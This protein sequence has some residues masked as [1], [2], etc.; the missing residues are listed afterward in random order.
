MLNVD[1]ENELI[2]FKARL[3]FKQEELLRMVHEINILHVS[4]VVTALATADLLRE[5]LEELEQILEKYK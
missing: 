5:S 2:E 1:L 3:E 4:K